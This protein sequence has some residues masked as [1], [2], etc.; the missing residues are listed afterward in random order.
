[1]IKSIR[2]KAL[3]RFTEG[4]ASKLPVQGEAT[5]QR[6]ARQLAVLDAAVKPE[7]MNIPGWK[8]HGLKGNPKRYAVWVTGNYR[9]TFAWENFDAI[10]VDIEDYH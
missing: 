5:L 10:A 8:F 7:D 6:L 4:D 3:I 1:M 9:V 2:S